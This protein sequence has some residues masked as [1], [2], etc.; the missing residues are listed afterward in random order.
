MEPSQYTAEERKRLRD[1]EGKIMNSKS[2]S[3]DNEEER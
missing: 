1:Y 2:N 3:K